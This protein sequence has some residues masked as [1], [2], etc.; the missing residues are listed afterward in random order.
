MNNFVNSQKVMFDKSGAYFEEEKFGPPTGNNILIKSRYSLASI[1]TETTEYVYFK[2]GLGVE[3]IDPNLPYQPDDCI[4]HP[5][6]EQGYAMSGDVIAIGPDVKNFITGNRVYAGTVHGNYNTCTDESWNIIKIPDNVT[7]EHS[8][9]VSLAGVAL[10]GVRRANIQLGE[11]VAV[12]GAGVVGLLTIQFA[13]MSG[14]SPVIVIDLNDERL[15]LAESLGADYVINPSKEPLLEKVFKYTHN[16]GAQCVIEAAGVPQ[17]LIS[18]MRI[19]ATCGRVVV[20]GSIRGEVTLNLFQDFVWRELTLI[21]AQQPRCPIIDTSYNHF[22]QQN[23]R[24]YCMDLISKGQL[25]VQPMITHI[26]PW[27][28]A[29]EMYEMLG[30]GKRTDF[31]SEGSVNREIIGVIFDWN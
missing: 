12:M 17:I 27:G 6:C 19:A 2:Y 3:K 18:A 29:I 23:N 10:H 1:G 15:K 21:A 13:K 8:T 9:F 11:S 31:F 26:V 4:L 22:T 24:K 14:A 7:Y 28:K 5:P 25:V 30:N 16:K 20:M